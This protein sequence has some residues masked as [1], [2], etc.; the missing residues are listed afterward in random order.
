MHRG[1]GQYSGRDYNAPRLVAPSARAHLKR[2]PGLRCR[3]LSPFDQ[4]EIIY[5]ALDET[6]D[7]KRSGPRWG[8][9]WTLLKLECHTCSVQCH[10][11]IHGPVGFHRQT[12]TCTC[13]DPWH[14]LALMCV[15]RLSLP[16]HSPL[17][18][19]ENARRQNLG[20]DIS[21]LVISANPDHN[22]VLVCNLPSQVLL[23]S[24]E[25]LGCGTYPHVF[26]EA[27]SC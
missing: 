20:H 15:L 4:H 7:E 5:V 16:K 26:R 13:G 2:R 18:L 21:C 12:P 24:Q 19:E 23:P 22:G 27:F 1:I 11:G 14:T 3:A 17:V 10:T 6:Q 9:E 25:M 8:R